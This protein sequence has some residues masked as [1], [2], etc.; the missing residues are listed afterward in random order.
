MAEGNQPALTLGPG[1]FFQHYC[2]VCLIN[3]FEKIRI[4]LL[5]LNYINHLNI[6]FI[7]LIFRFNLSAHVMNQTAVFHRNC[8]PKLFLE[9]FC[10]ANRVGC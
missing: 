5:S 4:I 9:K 6:T 3:T 2:H 10:A 7:F 1:D 8:L